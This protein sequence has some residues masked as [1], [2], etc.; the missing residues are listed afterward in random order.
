MSSFELPPGSAND[1]APFVARLLAREEDAFSELVRAYEGRIFALL[2]RM[3]G[4]RAEAEDLAQEVFVQVFKSI[5][6]FRGDA[7]LGTWLYRIAINLCKN[8][9]AYLARRQLGPRAGRTEVHAGHAGNADREGKEGGELEG[10]PCPSPRPDEVLSGLQTQ[11]I[12][13]EAIAAL[14]PDYREAL[15]LRDVEDLPYEEIA[16]ITG[17]PEGTVKSRLH[18]ARAQLRQLVDRAL[19]GEVSP[20]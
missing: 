7:K 10:A 1:E 14:E 6:Q 18:R 11:R 5:E 16:Q 12:V 15:V 17:V 19:R 4:D 2:L 13:R 9:R 20:R 8:R 3:L